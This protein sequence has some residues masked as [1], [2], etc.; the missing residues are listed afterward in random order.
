MPKQT[1]EQWIDAM[2]LNRTSKRRFT[3]T[4]EVMENSHLT[5]QM[6]TGPLVALNNPMSTWGHKLKFEY[7]K[8]E[9]DWGVGCATL[10]H[11][12]YIMI[13]THRNDENQINYI[14][15]M[16]PGYYDWMEQ[17]GRIKHVTKEVN[18]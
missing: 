12:D 1:L 7:V 18:N 17:N 16:E 4:Y 9:N 11:F 15:I 8:A 10:K 14:S 2:L 6:G 13:K 3:I 5:A